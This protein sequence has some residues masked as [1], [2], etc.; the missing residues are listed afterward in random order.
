MPFE[1]LKVA[2]TTTPVLILPN[3][4]EDF[5]IETDASGEGIGTI[6][7]QRDVPSP[8]LVRLSDPQNGRGQPMKK[9]CWLSWKLSAYGEHTYWVGISKF[10]LIR[11]VYVTCLSNALP[12]RNSSAG[13][14]SLWALIMRLCTN[15]DVKIM[16]LMHYH[17]GEKTVRGI[18][19]Q[20]G[21]II[22][23]F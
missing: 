15:Q 18:Y 8:S 16:P 22:P 10:A 17:E 23:H 11:E 21:D 7:S 1:R 5:I 14:Q 20:G 4:A 19:Q 3:F 6:L 9:R 12:R 13:L 2:L